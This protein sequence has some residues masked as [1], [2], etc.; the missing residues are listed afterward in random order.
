MQLKDLVKPIDKMSDEELLERLREI[1]HRKT[2]ERP[3]AKARVEK[4]EKKQS[5]G[6]MSAMDKLLAALTPEEQAE[7]MKSL[8][9]Q[10]GTEGSS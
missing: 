4:A 10:G 5:R 2:V 1:R 6:R 8:E 3:A 9:E 7:L